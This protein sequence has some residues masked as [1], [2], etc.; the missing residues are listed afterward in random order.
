MLESLIDLFAN[1]N[2]EHFNH[3]LRWYKKA[4]AICK[5]LSK[6]HNLPLYKVVGIMSALSPRNRWERNILDTESVIVS[7]LEAKVCTFNPN[8]EKAVK[9]LN[10]SSKE[11]VFRLLNG[12]KVQSFYN[13]IL[14]HKLSS[15]VTVDVWAMRSVGLDRAPNKTLYNQVEQAYKELALIVGLKPHEAQAICWGVIRGA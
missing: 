2:E 11:E 1:A 12:R 14:M 13:N 15:T 6:K 8:K 3:G 5:K 4:N 9:I 10:A 7:G